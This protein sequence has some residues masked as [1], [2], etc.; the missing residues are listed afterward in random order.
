MSF[1]Q[2]FLKKHGPHFVV[3]LDKHWLLSIFEK[4]YLIVDTEFFGFEVHKQIDTE[5]LRL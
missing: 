3:V 5:M 1:S 4:R 2:A